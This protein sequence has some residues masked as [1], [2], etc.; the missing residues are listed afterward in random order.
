[1]NASIVSPVPPELAAAVA[2]AADVGGEKDD[3]DLEYGYAE[4]GNST[5]GAIFRRPGVVY[6]I[7]PTG[8]LRLPRPKRPFGGLADAGGGGDGQ[9]QGGVGENKKREEVIFVVQVS[10]GGSRARALAVGGDEGPINQG[11]NATSMR[12]V[13]NSS[14]TTVCASPPPRAFP[15]FPSDV[16]FSVSPPT[17]LL[18]ESACRLLSVS[19]LLFL[20]GL[21]AASLCGVADRMLWGL[22]GNMQSNRRDYPE[23]SRCLEAMCSTGA[24]ARRFVM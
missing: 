16:I 1:M 23:L 8:H 24:W 6:P 20:Y 14:V 21:L 18:T 9:G 13:N 19:A 22:Q 11:T 10:V 17:L 2:A 15:H 5:F 12:P 7:H 3:E 4:R